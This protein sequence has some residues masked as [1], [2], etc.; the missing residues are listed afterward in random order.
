M[1]IEKNFLLLKEE[2]SKMVVEFEKDEKNY[3]TYFNN[4]TELKNY[5]SHL[6]KLQIDFVNELRNNLTRIKTKEEVQ[7]Y[8]VTMKRV[9]ELLGVKLDINTSTDF[10]GLNIKMV[11][12]ANGAI[13]CIN[14][15]PDEFM[16]VNEYLQCQYQTVQ[17]VISIIKEC[18]DNS[19]KP[20]KKK[21]SK[22]QKL[23]KDS[24]QDDI[25][26]YY[27]MTMKMKD[28]LHNITSLKEKLDHVEKEKE[29]LE[30]VFKSKGKDFYTSALSLLFRGRIDAYRE[31]LISEDIKDDHSYS[32][33]LVWNKSKTDFLELMSA[34]HLS[35]AI[36]LKNGDSLS[37]KD[38]V[39]IFEK[40]LNIGLIPDSDSRISKLHVRDEPCS[41]LK[42][43]QNAIIRYLTQK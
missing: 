41:F 43:L 20:G 28:D 5:Q 4:H 22:K 36:S 3:K 15:G 8:L 2:L 21:S 42:K 27:P 39:E 37:R 31:L 16:C 33:Q 32:S 17:D 10:T 9:F 38:Q 18:S 26:E 23:E 12:R 24:W 40:L 29:G 7:M 1:I 19:S 6:N 30:L 11:S 34:L 25:K 35:K 13:A 14:T